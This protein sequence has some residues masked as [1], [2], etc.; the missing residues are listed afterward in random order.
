MKLAY[1]LLGT[2]I[3]LLLSACQPTNQE[4]TTPENKTA[5]ST[6]DVT[7]QTAAPADNA[8]IS[9]PKPVRPNISVGDIRANPERYLPVFG[10]EIMELYF[11]TQSVTAVAGND[12]LQQGEL[13]QVGPTQAD[14]ESPEAFSSRIFDCADWAYGS[15]EE[16]TLD[17]IGNTTAEEALHMMTDYQAS[18]EHW[19]EV[20]LAKADPHDSNDETANLMLNFVC[21]G[22]KRSYYDAGTNKTNE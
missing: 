15:V 17:S 12:S 14:D 6:N 5:V 9:P 22:E 7:A 2:T 1:T 13:W 4:T 20:A 3:A 11:D 16:V 18:T 19:G 21:H 10:Y 8:S